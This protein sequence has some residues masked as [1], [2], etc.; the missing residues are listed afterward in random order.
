MKTGNPLFPFLYDKMWSVAADDPGE[1]RAGG[2]AL[3]TPAHVWNTPYDLTFRTNKTYEG[4]NGSF[5]FQY[6]VLAPLALAALLVARRRG[7]GSAA[8]VS[9]GAA[10]IV[11][12]TQPNARYV[13]ASLPLLSVPFAALLAWASGTRMAV[14]HSG[15]AGFSPVACI[16]MNLA[17]HAIGKLFLIIA[18]SPLRLPFSRAE[19]TVRYRTAAVPVRDVIDYFN[20]KHTDRA[21]MMAS[22]SG[23]AG[24]QGDV[25]ENHWHQIVN[26]WKIRDMKTVPDMVRLMQSWNVEYFISPKP[27]MDD[28]IKPAIFKEMLERC[29]EAEFEQGDEY[30]ARLQPTCK[31]RSRS[32][33]AGRR[34]TTGFYDDFDPALLFRCDWTQDREFAE[35]DRHTISFT[36]APGAEVEIDFTGKALT[37]VY[38]KAVNRGIVSVTVDG[39]EQGE[40]DLYSQQTQWQ[41]QTRFCCF[42]PGR[43]VAIVKVT[44]RKNPK[45]QGAFIDL[46]SFT[47][48]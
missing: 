19:R 42:G 39:V 10:A 47:V 46:D 38:T 32:R 22:E 16:A 33:T 4:Q 2:R 3:Q 29:T 34:A 17:L 6:L 21:V 20:R 24:L 13:Y 26:Y 1:C 30:L 31:P 27:G 36:D 18:I 8:V 15:A 7:V 14:R 9:L 28:D 40:M 25:Y 12:G 37:Y 35:P 43:H 11:M 44:G 5:G 45:S 48:E 23:I 41:S